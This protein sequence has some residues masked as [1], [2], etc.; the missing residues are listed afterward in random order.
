MSS[1]SSTWEREA[2]ESLGR[3]G[4]L[5][6]PHCTLSSKSIKSVQIILESL[7]KLNETLSYVNADYIMQVQL[8]SLLTNRGAPFPQDEFKKHFPN[9]LKYAQLFGPMM[10]E[11]IKQLI[12]CS[13]HYVTASSSPN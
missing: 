11:S 4:T 10:K 7:Q 9:V 2:A 5:Q 3:A 1:L 8:A 6:G 13:F 12:K